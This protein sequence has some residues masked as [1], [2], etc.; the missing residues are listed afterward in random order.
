MGDALDVELGKVSV[1]ADQLVAPIGEE[2]G[3]V[4]LEPCV[5]RAGEGGVYVKAVIDLR[6]HMRRPVVFRNLVIRGRD[7]EWEL[8]VPLTVRVAVEAGQELVVGGTNLL[9]HQFH[10]GPVIPRQRIEHEAEQAGVP[11]MVD[12]VLQHDCVSICDL[13][14]DHRGFPSVAVHAALRVRDDVVARLGHDEFRDLGVF[15]LVIWRVFV[16]LS[17]I[18]P[19][20]VHNIIGILTVIGCGG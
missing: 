19:G 10:L 14:G 5:A 3:Q 8:V 17:I 2:G 6:V 4:G 18:M 9:H 15:K 1:L 13:F 16:C 12:T 20:L 11:A 7:Q